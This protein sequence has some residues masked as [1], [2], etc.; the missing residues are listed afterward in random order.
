MELLL[1]IGI[2]VALLLNFMNGV[3]DA[4]NA[5]STIIATRVLTPAK[6][7]LLASV[8]NLVGPLFFTTAVAKTVGKGLIQPGTTTIPLII[9]ATVSAVVWVYVTTHFGIPSPPPAP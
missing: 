1:V 8:F 3:N 9:I 4:A 7:V 2:A 5:I 6:A